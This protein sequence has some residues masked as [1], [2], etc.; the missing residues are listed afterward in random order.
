M[1]KQWL[2]ISIV[3]L[4]SSAFSLADKYPFSLPEGWPSPEFSFKG[5]NLTE[6]KILLGR[7]LFYDPILSRDNSISCASCHSPFNAFA[8]TDHALSHGIHDSVGKRNAPA[9]MNLAW[10]KRFMW[11][12][13]AKSLDEQALIPITHPA[14]MG[15]RMDHLLEKLNQSPLYEK[16]F[17]DAF[18][19]NGISQKNLTAAITQFMLTLVS[20]NSRYD[21]VMRKQTT[22]TPQ[23]NRGYGLFR[24][25][26]ASCH[27]EPLFTNHS[28]K[29]NGLSLDEKL[30]DYAA[31]IPPISD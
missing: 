10:S 23:E 2:V 1:K 8:H 29:N 26:C 12:G 11:D 5:R 20:S 19:R 13:S 25:H 3:V 30:N 27:T 21:S 16:L 15:E 4:I 14:E 17:Q 31:G 28:F 24:N 18:G 6:E 7:V 9:L 22:F